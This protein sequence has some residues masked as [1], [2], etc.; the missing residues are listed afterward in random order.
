MLFLPIDSLREYNGLQNPWFWAFKDY[1]SKS[2]LREGGLGFFPMPRDVFIL[3][4]SKFFWEFLRMYGR[5]TIMVEGIYLPPKH[6]TAW[7]SSK[8]HEKQH[9][10]LHFWY[11]QTPF[12][13]SIKLQKPPCCRFSPKKLFLCMFSV[14]KVSQHIF[15][16]KQNMLHTHNMT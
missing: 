1:I 7:E 4:T 5:T 6:F 2:P 10:L 8:N 14:Q 3:M 13:V 11:L 16:I 9:F 12:G 15:E